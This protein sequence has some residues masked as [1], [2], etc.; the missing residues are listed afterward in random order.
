MGKRLDLTGQRFGRLVALKPAPDKNHRTMWKCIC[1][2]GN[3]KIIGLT[4]LRMGYTKSCGCYRSEQVRLRCWIDLTGQRFGKLTVI[5]PATVH[6]YDT[7][8]KCLCDCGK[9]RTTGT[10]A[11]RSGHTKSCGCYQKER[12]GASHRLPKE[13]AS[14]NATYSIYRKSA[15]KR[16]HN[17]NLS[18]K[19]FRII[20][21]Q[22]CFYCGAN[23][24]QHKRH[25]LYNGEYTYNGIDRINNSKGYEP[26]NV[27]TCCKKC[28]FMKHDHSQKDFLTHV[29]RIHK[30]QH[31]SK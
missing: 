26:K 17:F 5:E 24:S 16:G 7:M 28:N 31:N 8:W 10:Y 22:N 4:N 3:I 27:V 14:F 23:P 29:E 9:K 11:L 25:E 6:T 18:T 12:A 30:H 19:D 15:K 20:T 21:K 13:Q 2:C 1:D